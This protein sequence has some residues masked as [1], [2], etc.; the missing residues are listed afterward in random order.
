YFV[1]IDKDLEYWIIKIKNKSGRKND[2]KIFSAVELSLG[3]LH[4]SILDPYAYEL[5]VRTWVKDKTLYATK[6]F[7]I[8][9]IKERANKSWDKVNL[10]K[11][12]F[13]V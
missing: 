9:K 2:F 7:W 5:F 12:K 3:N 6:T 10:P 1:P 4:P 8:D 11:V 13:V